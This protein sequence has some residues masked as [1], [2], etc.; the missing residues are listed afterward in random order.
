MHS[1][2]KHVPI[3]YHFLRDQVID[4]TIKLE[5]IPT[6]EQ[7]V[8]IFNRPLCKEMFEYIRQKTSAISS[9]KGEWSVYY[10]QEACW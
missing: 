5:Y 10:N 4:Q 7:I 2:K 3:K 1:K 9:S 6:K 8:D